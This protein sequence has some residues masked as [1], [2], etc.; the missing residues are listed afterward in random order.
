MKN[1]VGVRM[2]STRE[3]QIISQ[4]CIAWFRSN[5]E[6]GWGAARTVLL[7]VLEVTVLEA[8]TNAPHATTENIQSK[9]QERC[10][11]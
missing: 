4:E 3:E 9:S 1:G 5:E 11:R 7:L 10:I 8:V 6:V 2:I